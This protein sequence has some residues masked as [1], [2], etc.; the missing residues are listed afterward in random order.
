MQLVPGARAPF[1]DDRGPVPGAPQQDV[2]VVGR[3]QRLDGCRLV[4][5]DQQERVTGREG[6]EVGHE[7]VDVVGR[8]ERGQPALRAETRGQVLGPGRQ[9]PVAQDVLAREDGGAVPVA[10]EIGGEGDPGKV[11]L[12]AHPHY[13]REDL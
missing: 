2:G 6:R 12:K 8:G 10:G 5:R 9:F 11:R 3:H 13:G 4:R 1:L 7:G